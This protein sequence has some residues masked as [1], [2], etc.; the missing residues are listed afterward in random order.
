MAHLKDSGNE[1]D[2]LSFSLS[3]VAVVAPEQPNG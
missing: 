2:L 1:C 3:Y